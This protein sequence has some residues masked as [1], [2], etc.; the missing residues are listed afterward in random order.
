M[1]TMNSTDAAY[2]G[3][4]RIEHE[5]GTGGFG[6]V[7]QAYQ[8]FLDRHV[9]IK[10]LHTDVTTNAKV[11]QQFM[12]EAR[13]IARLRHRGIVSVYEFG[14]LPTQPRPQT[15]MVMEFLSGET[16]AERLSRQKPSLSETVSIVEALAEAPD[17][18]HAHNVI[19]RDLK[20]ANVL[21]TES[22]EPVIV[23]FGLA[24]LIEIGGAGVESK[25]VHESGVRGTPAYMSPEQL[26][27]EAASTFSDQYALALIA[28]LTLSGQ[29]PHD[30]SHISRL[31][32]ER[33]EGR[34]TPITRHVPELSPAVDAVFA[35]A[36]AVDPKN[37]YPSAKEFATALGDALLPNRKSGKVVTVIDPLQAALVESTRRMMRSFL[38][39]MASVIFISLI[40]CLSFFLRGYQ[41]G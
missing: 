20:P 29:N 41:V 39:V 18:A 38:L 2:I 9:A 22:D 36:L 31:I 26:Q 8:P 27:G 24:K 23:D 19:H 33:L 21:F 10:T 25:D 12:H 30:V 14:T 15:Y 17:Y 5:L 32:A 1:T 35:K 37:R 28:Y 4:Y 16:L 34:A 7:Y 13:T 40:Y 11:E 3:P 6:V